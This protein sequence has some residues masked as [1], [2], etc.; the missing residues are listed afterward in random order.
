[1]LRE[2]D[3]SKHSVIVAEYLG[4]KFKIP[5]YS[6]KELEPYWASIAVAISKVLIYNR[7]SPKCYRDHHLWR[8]NRMGLEALQFADVL[9]RDRG[10]RQS[11]RDFNAQTPHLKYGKWLAPFDSGE[12]MDFWNHLAQ[13]GQ[14]INNAMAF[15]RKTGYL[16]VYGDLVKVIRP[17][18]CPPAGWALRRDLGLKTCIFI[19]YQLR[20]TGKYPS[21]MAI[22]EHWRVPRYTLIEAGFTRDVIYDI[23][24]HWRKTGKI[25][26]IK[27]KKEYKM[28]SEDEQKEIA[29]RIAKRIYG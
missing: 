22:A 16:V 23:Y 10:F 14:L 24:R 2:I 12:S 11:V 15:L 21:L 9:T 25:K 4:Y 18:W 20:K 7:F 3:F 17:Y 27:P 28:V 8:E 1:M 19:T 6:W 29:R 26:I 13:I 5:I